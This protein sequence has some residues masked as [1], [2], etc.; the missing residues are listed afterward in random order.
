MLC[1]PNDKRG[2]GFLFRIIKCHLSEVRGGKGVSKEIMSVKWE[3][4]GAAGKV[5]AGLWNLCSPLPGRLVGT[6]ARGKLDL[7]MHRIMHTI[8]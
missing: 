8:S 7:C 3:M 4:L 2:R 5:R 1:L 6:S